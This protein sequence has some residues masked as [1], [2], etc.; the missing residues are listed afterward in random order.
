MFFIKKIFWI[1]FLLRNLILF[2]YY[3]SNWRIKWKIYTEYLSINEQ[4]SK[5]N[6]QTKYNI[7]TWRI[8][9]IPNYNGFLI[10]VFYVV[11]YSRK[12]YL[13]TN[14]LTQNDIA[15]N[16]VI[17]KCKPF[18]HEDENIRRMVAS[19]GTTQEDTVRVILWPKKACFGKNIETFIK[20]V[21]D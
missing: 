14:Y 15:F 12:I 1:T 3:L 19:T 20:H 17:V 5:T 18:V 2:K 21:W 4:H 10:Y 7:K 16:L 6:V 13:V 11:L 9:R 8:L